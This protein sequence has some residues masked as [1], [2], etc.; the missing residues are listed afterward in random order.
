[1][2]SHASCINLLDRKNNS[3]KRT[4][5]ADIPDNNQHIIADQQQQRP[6]HHPGKGSMIQEGVKRQT[7]A[8]T[9]K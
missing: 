7:V 6:A 3:Y 8:E 1:M 9:I 4:S 2:I 5:L